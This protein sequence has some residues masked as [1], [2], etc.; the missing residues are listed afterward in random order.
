MDP[1]LIQPLYG[2]TIHSE[3]LKEHG[4][5]IHHVKMYY[6]DIPKAVKSFEEQGIYP[7]QS[8]RFDKDIQGWLAIRLDF[9]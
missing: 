2:T 9:V 5:G 8:G 3:F 7:L 1:E 4:E 6:K